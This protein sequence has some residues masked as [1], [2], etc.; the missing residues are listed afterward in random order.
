M[1]S[2]A[3]TCNKERKPSI[4]PAVNNTTKTAGACRIKAQRQ[5]CL[6][7][8]QI[9]RAGGGLSGREVWAAEEPSAGQ[10]ISVSYTSK[11]MAPSLLLYLPR[12]RAQGWG[13]VALPSILPL[14]PIPKVYGDRVREDTALGEK[15]H[16]H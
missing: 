15:R 1:G 2:P 14:H 6:Q 7:I 11:T 10:G 9:S 12:P 5:E 13:G 3:G 4:L 16:G 8:K